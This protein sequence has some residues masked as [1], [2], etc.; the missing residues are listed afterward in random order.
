M[1]SL[2]SYQ[3]ILT[4]LLK[5]SWRSGQKLLRTMLLSGVFLS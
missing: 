3:H 2:D 1:V 5:I 4:L